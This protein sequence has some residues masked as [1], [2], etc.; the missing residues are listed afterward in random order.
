MQN[1][2]SCRERLLEDLIG[3]QRKK[4][5]ALEGEVVKLKEAFNS[6]LASPDP[7]NQVAYQEVN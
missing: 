7:H 1:N 5:Q 3:I 6:H 2:K 4:L